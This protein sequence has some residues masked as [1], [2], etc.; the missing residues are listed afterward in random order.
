MG[1]KEKAAIKIVLDTNILISSLLFKGELAGVVDLWKKGKIIPIFSRDT[2]DE[3][4][5]VLEYPKFSLTAQE[6][7][8]I[9]EEEVLPFFEVI[10]VTDKIKGACRDADDDKFIACAVS[11]SAD[12]IVTGDKDLLD[13]GKYK[14]VKILSA[15]EF[16]RMFKS[17]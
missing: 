1:K 4:K 10:E 5:T 17:E 9:I 3:F 14:S 6:M 15:S 13:M 11:A 7:K 16:L 2:F 12:F 8:V